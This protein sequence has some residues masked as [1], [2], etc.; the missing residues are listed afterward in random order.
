MSRIVKDFE[1]PVYNVRWLYAVGA[2][3]HA[4]ITI[5]VRDKKGDL[6]GE[7]APLLIY[8]SDSA[9]GEGLAATGSSGVIAAGTSGTV[10]QE[11]TT[12]KAAIVL[13]GADG[14]FVWDVVDDT[15]QVYY[16]CA[17][18]LAGMSGFVAVSRILSAADFGA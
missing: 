7:V 18:P 10:L 15:T 6:I 17:A 13:T 9:S 2:E 8:I 1:S 5:E 14:K 4:T 3:D 16:L 12:K 11:L